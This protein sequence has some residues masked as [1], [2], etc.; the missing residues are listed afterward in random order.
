MG[1]IPNDYA[2]LLIAFTLVTLLIYIS[3][4]ILNPFK[5]T[6]NMENPIMEKTKYGI[7][8]GVASIAMNMSAIGSSIIAAKLDSNWAIAF[9]RE[10]FHLKSFVL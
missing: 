7:K 3:L 5:L 8:L 1:S 6:T 2:S 9:F 10:S 4:F